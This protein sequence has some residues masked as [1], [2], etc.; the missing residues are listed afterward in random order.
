[1]IK[2][3]LPSIA[4]WPEISKVTVSSLISTYDWYT[5]SCLTNSSIHAIKVLANGST[6]N[7]NTIGDD[8]QRP[9]LN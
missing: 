5:S 1:M 9:A 6:Q 3:I 8:L 7:R 4:K 2:N